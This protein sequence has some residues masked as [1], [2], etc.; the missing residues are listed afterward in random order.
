[1]S[2][3][4]GGSLDLTARLYK[5]KHAKQ[6]G[7]Q[8]NKISLGYGHGYKRYQERLKYGLVHA[9]WVSKRVEFLPSVSGEA[10]WQ[11]LMSSRFT[12]PLL[13]HWM[14]PII[15]KMV[16]LGKLRYTWGYRCKCGILT[17]TD[18]ELDSI[19][20]EGIRSGLLPIDEWTKPEEAQAIAG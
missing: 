18:R 2:K 8:F 12:T 3:T 14:R 4:K 6:F 7:H 13:R 20:S 19:V 5:G 1:M 11:S 9:I 17:A 16:D 10:M 15:S